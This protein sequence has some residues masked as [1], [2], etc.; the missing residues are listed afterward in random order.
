M[1]KI[2]KFIGISLIILSICSCKA[3]H[4]DLIEISTAVSKTQSN[5]IVSKV[6]NP[7]IN[8]DEVISDNKRE[9]VTDEEIDDET[10]EVED[11]ETESE[12]GETSLMVDLSALELEVVEDDRVYHGTN[13]VDTVGWTYGMTPCEWIY[14]EPNIQLVSNYKPNS[15][16]NYA[17]RSKVSSG[18]KG[19]YIPVFIKTEM[20]SNEYDGRFYV[21]ED[22]TKITPDN[23]L[24]S[25]SLRDIKYKNFAIEDILKLKINLERT[26]NGLLK[27]GNQYVNIV[28]VTDL[29][30]IL[31]GRQ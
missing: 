27:N 20:L 28:Y 30:N 22:Y 25:N 12:D 23:M 7:T 16:P 3:E 4:V 18:L 24:F 13:V 14:I 11:A 15:S 5:G 31:N 9:T 6:V 26:E 21:F 1:K 19:C 10:T 17:V 2:L 8:L 29:D